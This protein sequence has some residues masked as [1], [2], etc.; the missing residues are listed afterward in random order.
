MFSSSLSFCGSQ[1]IYYKPSTIFEYFLIAKQFLQLS[2]VILVHIYIPVERRQVL[3]SVT[4]NF[5]SLVLI[6]R[7]L[8]P[9]PFFTEIIVVLLSSPKVGSSDTITTKS[10]TFLCAVVELACV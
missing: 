4:T 9:I 1:L 8:Q 7:R 6:V 10:S 5:A 2:K 3:N